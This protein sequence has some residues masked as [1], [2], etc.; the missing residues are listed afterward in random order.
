MAHSILIIAYYVIRDGTTYKDLGANYFDER[1]KEK[2]I[3]RCT[4]RIEQLGK[5]VTVTDAA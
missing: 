1:D 3:R 4:Q 2:V 5:K